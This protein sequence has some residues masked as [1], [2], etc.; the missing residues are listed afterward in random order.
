MSLFGSLWVGTS[1]LATSQNALNTT[2]HNMMNADT[3]G[4]T[5]EQVL[6]GTRRYTTIAVTPKAAA[7]QQV[8]MG[9]N[10]AR[11]EQ[12][13]DVFLDQAYRKESG[14]SSFYEASMNT[15]NQIEDILGEMDGADF[16]ESLQDL[17]VAIQELSK[18]PSGSTAQGLLVTRAAQF[19]EHG[20][21]VYESIKM[22]QDQL[23]TTVSD[24][25]D[26]INDY[27]E[28]VYDLNKQIMKIESG[29]IERANDLRD[30]RNYILDQLGELAN[31]TYEEDVYGAM[32][33]RIEQ[34]DLL[35][36][37]MVFKIESYEDPQTA[38]FTPIWSDRVQRDTDG[39]IVLTE[40]NLREGQVFDLQREISTEMDT[41]VG[42]LKAILLARGDH[43]ATF[44]DIPKEPVEADCKDFA[45]Y[46]QK[47]MEYE[48]KVE[49]YNLT[50]AQSVCMNIMG[51]FD[52]LIHNIC[53]N[54]NEVLNDSGYPS[55]FIPKTGSETNPD[56]YTSLNLQINPEL[57][58]QPSKLSFL[59]EDHQA[60][61]ET[62]EKLKNIFEDESYVLNPNVA[63]KVNLRFYYN[64]LVNQVGNSASV[65][66]SIY[67]SEQMTLKGVEEARQ[68]VAGVST[69]EE[70]QNM[71]MFQNAYNASSRY[72][73]VVN[74]MLDYLMNSLR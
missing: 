27:A 59:K 67:D 16:N 31:I 73:T 13:R 2:A 26:Q 57:T 33:I 61:Y 38:F 37:D 46:E 48:A 6:Q 70:L 18:D 47:F 51:E 3:K 9:V 53:W 44:E 55:L 23:N 58:K 69:D 17:W 64:S 12:I 32:S 28:E 36:G 50:T 72:I 5:R 39:N 29:D 7:N 15:M 65:Y 71:I 34:N 20:A 22:Y 42:K 43:R 62:A 25:V 4:Y 52:S 35:K 56:F 14:R 63:M 1:G 30:R 54:M 74:S 45:E 41:D 49:Q 60:D 68:S 40:K 66:Q 10:Y 21:S 8:G 24:M 11:T 19:I